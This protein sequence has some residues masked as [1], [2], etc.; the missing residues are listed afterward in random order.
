MV[1][2]KHQSGF[3]LIEL[4][5]VIVILGVLSAFALPRFANLEGS[6]EQAVVEGFVGALRSA[7]TLAFS[8]MMLGAGYRT[9]GDVSL[10]GI[11]RCDRNEQF[12]PNPGGPP[13]G[14]HYLA[15]ASLRT[16]I[17]RDPDETA[18]N[19]NSIAFTTRSGRSVQITQAGGDIT[20][21][22]TPSF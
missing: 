2:I 6:A 18:C 3:T 5:T 21:T 19:G 22:A 4:I 14:G 20:W 9:R 15:L 11:T 12:G 17:F 1:S 7:H 10:F 8:S 13:W 16:S